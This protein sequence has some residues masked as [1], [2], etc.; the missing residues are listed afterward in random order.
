[1]AVERDWGKIAVLMGGL[2]AEREI[3]LESGAAVLQAL[4]RK[5]V[6]AYGIDVDERVLERLLA[7]RFHRIFIALHGRGG[8]DGGI[9]GTL[10]TLGLP[11]TG[12]GVLGSALAMDK[13]RSKQ[14]WR[15]MQLPTADF[16][17][18]NEGTNLALVVASLGLPLIVKPARGGSSLGIIKVENI[19]ALRAA[20]REAAAFDTTIFAER[21]LPGIEY[22]V[23]ILGGQ[24]LPLIRLETPRAF[25]DFEAKYLAD[26]TRYLCPCGLSEEQERVLQT[27]ALR[28]F[29]ALGASGWGR[30]DFRCDEKD[31]PYLLEVNTV[32]GMTAH[33]LVPMAARAAGIEF[34]DLVLRIMESSEKRRM[35]EDGGR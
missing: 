2:S 24:V 3:S 9:Q 23:G 11:Y 28:S 13:L 15:G 8:E 6:N 5:G 10:E 21:W 20:Y 22:T 27:L 32:P 34:D 25:Y 35:S 7:G 18:L 4:L 33:S 26:T 30:V 31:R 12:S 17:M 16:F 1:M 19:K 14:L 29:H